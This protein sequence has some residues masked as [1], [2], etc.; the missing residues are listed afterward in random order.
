MA[1]QGVTR[2]P[3]VERESNKL[4]GLVSLEGVL[5][6]RAKH[7]EDEVKRDQT[8]WLPYFGSAKT[9]STKADS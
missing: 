7:Q 3:V 1:D 5:I 9:A 8:L 6:A 4:L 2:M